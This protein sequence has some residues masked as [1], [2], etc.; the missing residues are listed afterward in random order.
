MLIRETTNTNG[1]DVFVWRVHRQFGTIIRLERQQL[2]LNTQYAER[3]ENFVFEILK[4]RKKNVNR[5]SKVKFSHLV[6]IRNGKKCWIC[7]HWMN[8]SSP[9]QLLHGILVQ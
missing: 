8:W 3:I 5:S 4:S 2:A 6:E 9:R 7:E 1:Y